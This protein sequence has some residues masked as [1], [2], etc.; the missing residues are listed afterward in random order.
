M[1]VGPGKAESLLQVEQGLRGPAT[2]L[3]QEGEFHLIC[4]QLIH[5]ICILCVSLSLSMFL[6]MSGL[7]ASRSQ[8]EASQKEGIKQNSLCGKSDPEKNLP[9]PILPSERIL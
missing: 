3:L 4:P 5:L 1:P 9:L 2:G 7:S 6:S 8:K